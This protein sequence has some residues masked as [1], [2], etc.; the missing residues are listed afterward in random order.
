[1]DEK[2][3]TGQ[4]KKV[5]PSIDGSD[6]VVKKKSKGQ[7]AVESFLGEEVQS[8]K[9]HIVY[10]MIIPSTK[11]A[12]SNMFGGII[13]F[14]NDMFHEFIDSVLFGPEGSTKTKA[15][16]TYVSYQ[17]YYAKKKGTPSRVRERQES[18][19]ST[20]H[21]LE[22]LEFPNMEKA[23]RV[24]KDLIELIE[25]YQEASVADL[26]SLAEQTLDWTEYKEKDKYGWKDASNIGKPRRRR[27]KYIIPLP[28]PVRLK[29][30]D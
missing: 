25:D 21:D 17:G 6:V 9:D 14:F 20:R 30:E 24:R 27:G 22:D 26:F 19:L 4:K 13:D 29:Q 8:V 1:M 7:K 11:D 2:Q 28:R 10:D 12:M 15:S 23:A 16:E 3:V 18:Y 5:E